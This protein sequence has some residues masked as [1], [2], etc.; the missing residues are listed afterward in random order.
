MCPRTRLTGARRENR[1]LN[2]RTSAKRPPQS[3]S[4]SGVCRIEGS[5]PISAILVSK[6]EERPVVERRRES[7]SKSGGP[8]SKNV[9]GKAVV[10]AADALGLTPVALA[11]VLGLSPASAARLV[12][13][14]DG[15]GIKSRSYELALLVIRLYR[16]LHAMLGGEDQAIRS[17]MQTPNHA[18]GGAPAD[19][20]VAA[21]G[22]VETVAY[23]EASH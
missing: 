13:G 15:L 3:R 11:A 21:N 6:G 9:V 12:D 4:V 16:G 19:R 22:L 17:W 7:L 18:L 14:A 1:D 5:T 2:F 10:R 20:V 8:K 23:V